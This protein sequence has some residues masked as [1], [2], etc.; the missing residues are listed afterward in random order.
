MDYIMKVSEICNE[1]EHRGNLKN[2][3]VC[4]IRRMAKNPSGSKTKQDHMVGLSS[5]LQ[6]KGNSGA[7][8]SSSSTITGRGWSKF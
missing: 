6:K 7:F 5:T 1:Y 4:K 2:C 8:G 3:L